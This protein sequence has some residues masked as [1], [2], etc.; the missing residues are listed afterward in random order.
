MIS[1]QPREDQHRG[2]HQ[3]DDRGQH[4]VGGDAVEHGLTLREVSP[5]R[6]LP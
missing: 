5:M 2:G 6:T 1:D 4:Q 3:A